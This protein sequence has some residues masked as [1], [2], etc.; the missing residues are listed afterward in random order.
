METQI[1]RRS[2][3]MKKKINLL[4]S[5]LVM[6]CLMV[7]LGVNAS[8]AEVVKNGNC[9]A[10]GDNVTWTFYDDGKLIISGEGATYDYRWNESP[11][12]G[13]ANVKTVVIEDGVT[14]IGDYLFSY[15]KSIVE[16]IIPESVTS[17]SENNFENSTNLKAI[18]V[19]ENNESFLSEN[20]VLFN[21]DKTNLIKYPTAKEGASYTV[22]ESVVTLNEKAF[23]YCIN[24]EKVILGSKVT[25]LSN[26]LFNWCENLKQV[27][28]LG[29]ITEIG[30]GAFWGCGS[31]SN[32]TIPDSVT[33]IGSHAFW[34]CE[35]LKTVNIPENVSYIGSQAFGSCDSLESITVD[36]QNNYYSAENGVLYNKDKTELVQYPNGKKDSV[37]VVNENTETIKSYAVYY[38]EYLEHL[39][40][41]N[42]LTKIESSGIYTWNFLRIYYAGTEEDWNKIE[43]TANIEYRD[44]KVYYNTTCVHESSDDRYCDACGK[45][46][47]L[48]N[49][50]CGE[51]DG[52]NVVWTLYI[53]GDFVI[54]GSG[55]MDY[56]DRAADV[57]SMIK[58]VIIEPGV[59][60]T[61]EGLFA[62]F[63]AI[64]SVT[65][66]ASMTNIGYASFANCMSLKSIT[67]DKN[68]EYYT[69]DNGVLFNKDKSVLITYP[70]GN[71][72]TEYVVPDSVTSIFDGAFASSVNL[73]EIV[74]PDSVETIGEYAFIYSANLTEVDIP[75]SVTSIGE[76]V[77]ECCEKLESVKIGSSVASIGDGAFYECASL[78]NITVDIDNEYYLSDDYGALFDIDKTELIVY[79]AAS[80]ETRYVVPDSVTSILDCAFH[81]A[82]N[83][84][85]VV[86]PD[87]VTTIGS[88]VFRG[89]TSLT[90]MILPQN[91]TTI[92]NSVFCDCENLTSVTI[93]SGVTSFGFQAFKNCTKLTDVYFNG[94]EEQWNNIEID[95]FNEAVEE[96]TVHFNVERLSNFKIEF[97]NGILYVSGSA[98][99][100]TLEADKYPWSQ[101]ATETTQLI[102]KDVT[103]VEANAFVD[104]V[105][106][107]SVIID[108]KTTTILDDEQMIYEFSNVKIESGAFSGCKNLSV[109]VADANINFANDAISGADRTVKYFINAKAKNNSE[110]SFITFDFAEDFVV[111]EENK[112]PTFNTI[113]DGEVSLTETEF[114]ALV[115]ALY[116]VS[117]NNFVNM[118]FNKLTAEDF[119]IFECTSYSPLQGKEI[120]EVVGSKIFG[121]MEIDP[122]IHEYME[123]T[124]ADLCG[125][126][127]D[128]EVVN[129]DYKFAV[130]GKAPEVEDED[131]EDN[132]DNNVGEPDAED[133]PAEEE[134]KEP[135]IITR[136]FATILESFKKI[137]SLIKKLFS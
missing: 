22:P 120:T 19:D 6:L 4:F 104:F 2:K 114:K 98:A 50:I 89:C 1:N 91:I 132:D 42:N 119:Y 95:Y 123:V 94:T 122:D 100:P 31:L 16:I 12:Y 11:L 82:E 112:I 85:Q 62:E 92:D 110:I 29:E 5:F 75:N 68:N 35:L 53:N 81:K 76:G 128:A 126:L 118:V 48:G 41:H 78:K 18:K 84:T 27:E 134:I 28:F 30:D 103:S 101:Y 77:F 96:A 125:Y 130:L 32:I 9:G 33:T 115:L 43:E 7:C 14:H 127:N 57:V 105:N 37:F 60:A 73:T 40:L 64:E 113:I 107:S 121:I 74:I 136:F 65:I 56:P 90:S 137:I 17:I 38:S 63:F 67:V 39:V 59:T 135:N 13:C 108:G 58:N 23:D 21:K 52:D 131:K 102:L 24:I 111:I 34:S 3:S 54:S 69:S 88:D 124:L 70:A 80:E 49:G 44:V 72:A 117:D 106:L 20:G 71:T 46:V 36:A 55:A 10:D 45:I 116:Y 15:S 26:N 8:A 93:P 86:I 129:F 97:G 25:N 87:S 109:V 99:I 66:P 47:E 83:L 51:N 133:E 79:P 61:C